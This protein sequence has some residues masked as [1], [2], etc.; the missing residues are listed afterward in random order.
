MSSQ[1]YGFRSG[2]STED[3]VNEAIKLVEHAPQKYVVAIVV[4]IAGAF[5]HLWWPALFERLRDLKCP[6]ALYNCFKNYCENREA[7]LSCP[8]ETITKEISKGCPQGSISGPVFWDL[9][10]DPVLGKLQNNEEVVGVVA[11]ADD[12]M[13]LVKGSSRR[14]LGYGCNRVLQ[15][16]HQWCQ[17]VKLSIAPEKTTYMLLKGN[18]KRG[19]TMKLSDRSIKR[20]SFTRYLGVFLDERLNYS[21]HIEE[22]SKRGR[23]MMN[24]IISL[25]SYDYML[26]IQTIRT[27]HNAILSAIM[28]Y[29][30]SAWAHRLLLVTPALIVNRVQR[31]ILLRLSGAFGTVSIEALQVILGIC[32]LDL[33]IRKK[34][35]IYWLKKEQYQEVLKLIGIRA[36]CKQQIHNQ[37]LH[38]W[39]KR[40]D[41]AETGRRTYNFLPNIKQRLGM[42]YLNPSRGLTHFLSGHG[43]YAAYW[44]RIGRRDTS[45]CACGEE[46]T[47]EHTIWRCPLYADIVD[48]DRQQLNQHGRLDVKEI[49]RSETALQILDNIT[50]AIS[51]KAWVARYLIN[52][53]PSTRPR[54]A[55]EEAEEAT[56]RRQLRSRVAAEEQPTRH[57]RSS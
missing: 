22:T 51:R 40:W 20:K 52:Q 12:L 57:A 8:G 48:A 18:L 32:P 4:D 43:P 29:C 36:T 16:L 47:P 23:N 13:I 45:E 21:D 55:P 56:Q 9:V 3:A 19:P 37:I 7:T 35:A 11:Y 42:K 49:L 39:Q 44:H 41:D 27:Y 15:Q 46:G 14:N 38:L 1:Q 5:D 33:Q 54:G 31:G 50:D 24:K 28:G 26:P 30:A 53:R 6:R 2:K 17:G 25:A 10:L 34:A